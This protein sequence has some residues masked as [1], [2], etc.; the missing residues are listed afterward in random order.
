[1]TD[2]EIQNHIEANMFYED[3]T[4]MIDTQVFY[5]GAKWMRDHFKNQLETHEIHYEF[6]KYKSSH[7]TMA[8]RIMLREY[9]NGCIR[10]IKDLKKTFY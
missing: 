4:P 7:A 3:G 1:M 10:S 9:W 2:K 5:E 8:D 6:Q